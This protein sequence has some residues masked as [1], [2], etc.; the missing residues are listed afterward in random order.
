LSL[1]PDSDNAYAIKGL[2]LCE[3]MLMDQ[4]KIKVK[5]A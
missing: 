5:N 4:T 3:Q 1:S 2:E